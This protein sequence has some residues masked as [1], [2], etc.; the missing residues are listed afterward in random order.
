MVYFKDTISPMHFTS[1]Q[2]TASSQFSQTARQSFR[3]MKGTILV[4]IGSVFLSSPLA[5]AETSRT[6]VSGVTYV[7]DTTASGR[8]MRAV[9]VSTDSV[10][11]RV[12][13]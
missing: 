3:M 2:L 13:S 4:L 9:V 10:G 12:E 11:L 1:D 5:L 7:S 8:E 6:L